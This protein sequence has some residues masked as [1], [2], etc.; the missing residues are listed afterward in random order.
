MNIL[1]ALED[2]TG[3]LRDVVEARMAQTWTALPVIVKKASDGHTAQMQSAINQMVYD[4]DGVTLLSAAMAEFQDAP[5][6]F[7]GG[8]GV[9][10][11]HPVNSG[12]EGIALFMSRGQDNWHEQG[13]FQYPVDA[14]MHHLSDARFIPGGRSNPRKMNPAPSSDSAQ[15]RSDDGNHV[16]DI[17]PTN[18]LHSASTVKVAV[19]SGN[20]N[21]FHTP[22][23]IRSLATLIAHNC[24]LP[25]SGF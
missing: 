14:R 4:V 11:T 1:E 18:G 23:G 6:H 20:S 21:T 10:S 2:L 5:V 19:T 17:H 15:H 9:S 13:G 8:G 12:D 25:G 7:A 16:H 3:S 22:D 24:G